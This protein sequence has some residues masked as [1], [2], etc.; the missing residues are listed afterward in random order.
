MSQFIPLDPPIAAYY[1]IVTDYGNRVFIEPGGLVVAMMGGD[2]LPLS[3][4]QPDGSWKEQ[5]VPAGAVRIE[6]RA[7][8][9]GYVIE[10]EEPNGDHP[11]A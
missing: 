3:V 8:V 6:L 4:R 9:G 11:A 5:P 7:G 2:K 10:S 1:S